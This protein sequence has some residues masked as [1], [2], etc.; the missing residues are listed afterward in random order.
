LD[1]NQWGNRSNY[2]NLNIT[3]TG[4]AEMSIWHRSGYRYT[5]RTD[6]FVSI[7]AGADKG[8]F[9]TKPLTFTGQ[10]LVVNYSTSAAGGL[11]VELQDA[12]GNPL[13]GYRLDDCPVIV[14]DEIE[15]VV[16]WKDV[17][18]LATPAGKPVRLRFVM[19]EC[20]VYSVRFHN[21]E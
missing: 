2:A 1:P 18:S 7:R 14:G 13:E 11:Q 17:P 9:V 8:E 20:D 3:P 4:S 12:D 21:G 10:K 5:L 16:T 6:G 15:H 19:N